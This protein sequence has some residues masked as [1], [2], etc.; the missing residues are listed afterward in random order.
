MK[1]IKVYLIL[2]CLSFF[3][4]SCLN[5]IDTFE[6]DLNTYNLIESSTITTVLNEVYIIEDN[7]LNNCFEFNY[8]LYLNN[9]NN[10]TFEIVN[11]N[12]LEE[13]ALSQSSDFHINSI[14]IPFSITL[15]NVEVFI[16]TED[17]LQEII[18]FCEYNSLYQTLITKLPTC[19]NLNYPIN[20]IVENNFVEFENEIDF[21]N[22][23]ETQNDSFIPNINYPIYTYDEEIINNDFE[24]YEVLN[25][26]E[27]IIENCEDI[28]I[29]KEL[30]EGN[31]YQFNIDSSTNEIANIEW[32]INDEFQNGEN[33]TEFSKIFDVNEDS[34][35]EVCSLAYTNNCSE[36]SENC[37]TVLIDVLDCNDIYFDYSVEYLNDY[38]DVNLESSVIVNESSSNIE[39]EWIIDSSTAEI[40]SDYD[41][42]D[43][44]FQAFQDFGTNIQVCIKVF[45]PNCPDG[46]TYCEN[47]P[48]PSVV[49]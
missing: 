9:N 12:G 18:T 4:Q 31:Y 43:F 48:I 2:F 45:S 35:F 44:Q 25:S 24:L 16:N 37:T 42:R 3:S 49:D 36:P 39:Y 41:A 40:I 21:I 20:L 26:C 32:Y 47:I 30:I 7:Q 17:D 11:E 8:P 13:I 46:T 10:L 19:L 38:Y 23:L 34:E 22:F 29:R 5:E 1:K 14:N 33:S 6:N 15:N 27:I 28:E